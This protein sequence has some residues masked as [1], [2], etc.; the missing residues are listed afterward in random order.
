M[1]GGAA[2]EFSFGMID[3]EPNG[4]GKSIGAVQY[5]A[6]G[7]FIGRNYSNMIYTYEEAGWE[8]P[9]QGGMKP[10][11]PPSF[12][13]GFRVVAVIYWTPSMDPN[14]ALVCMKHL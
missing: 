10:R 7:G 4:P 5:F 1:A 2:T 3:S 11:C 13:R 14:L 12:P 6:Q 8:L 9:G